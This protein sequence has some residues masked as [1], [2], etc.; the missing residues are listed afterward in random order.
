MKNDVMTNK[1]NR[2]KNLICFDVVSVEIS[3]KY[4]Y[5]SSSETFGNIDQKCG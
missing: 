2:K 5:V 4:A 3:V 1:C